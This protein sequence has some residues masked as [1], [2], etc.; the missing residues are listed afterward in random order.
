M[1]IDKI[2]AYEN[3]ELS[4]A[5]T[6]ELFAELISTGTAWVLQGSYGRMA[7]SFIYNR[8]IDDNGNILIDL[9]D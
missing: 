5:A 6:V 2:M 8:M 4:W 9:E 1:M 3:E 7:E